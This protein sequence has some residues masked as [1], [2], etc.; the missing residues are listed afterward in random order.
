V[1]LTHECGSGTRRRPVR[2]NVGDADLGL[3]N[4]E[5]LSMGIT[6]WNELAVV[7]GEFM[8][9]VD[10][11]RERAIAFFVKARADA[12]SRR[13]ADIVPQLASIMA[14]RAFTVE[15]SVSIRGNGLMD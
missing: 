15:S 14:S 11:S 8:R 1:R 9:G 5:M 6:R 7:A 13:L 10:R 12:E 2:A 3:Q 4:F